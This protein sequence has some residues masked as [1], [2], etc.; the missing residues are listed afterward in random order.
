ARHSKRLHPLF[1]RGELQLRRRRALEHHLLQVVVEAHDLVE[2]DAPF[3][4]RAVARAAAEALEELALR[5]L[6]L[7][8]R[9][10]DLLERAGI[11]LDRLPAVDA[12][13]A[14]ETLCEN[15]ID[16]RRDEER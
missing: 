8:R 7:I 1:D 11:D 6:D 2:R 5:H 16:R 15:E 3:V 13:L 9:E 10:A 4:S 12:H 14:R